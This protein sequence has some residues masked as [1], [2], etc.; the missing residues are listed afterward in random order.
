MAEVRPRSQQQPPSNAANPTARDAI[1][2]TGIATLLAVGAAPRPTALKVATLVGVSVAA[3]APVVALATSKPWGVNVQSLR[4]RAA[5]EQNTEA[6]GRYRAAYILTASRR[7]QQSLANGVSL[8]KTMR[9]EQ[10]FFA[11]HIEA[12]ANRRRSALMVDQAAAKFGLEL[13]WYAKIDSRTSPECRAANGRNF[14]V[15]QVPVIGWPGAVHPFCR[16]RP[17]KP[18]KTKQDVYDIKPDRRSA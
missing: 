5:T 8:D 14:S 13:G 7:V 4:S 12:Q 11:Q 10:R 17:G 3:V 2:V 1:L 9:D 15:T 16:C 18:Y 6:E